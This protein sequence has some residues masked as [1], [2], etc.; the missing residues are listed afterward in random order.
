MKEFKIRCSSLSKIM[1]G[2]I[3]ASESQLKNIVKMEAREKPMTSDQKKK[4]DLDIFARDNPELPQG[5]MTYCEDWLK[6]QVYSQR[7]EVYSKA[8]EKGLLCEDEAIKLVDPKATKNKDRYE[9]SYMTGEPDLLIDGIVRDIKCSWDFKT[10]PLTKNNIDSDYWWQLQG[11]MILCN[12]D[13][14]SLDYC[15][16]NTPSHLDDRNIKYDHLPR[17]FRVKSY[18]IK[19]E[20]DLY[21]KII[22]RVIMCRRYIEDIKDYLEISE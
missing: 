7:I 13:E 20:D 21:D 6:E 8:I 18:K 19:R 15:L 1:S 12:L 5:A 16:V 9:S 4:Y 3:G 11:Y 10:F 14:A 22:E 2:S 17:K